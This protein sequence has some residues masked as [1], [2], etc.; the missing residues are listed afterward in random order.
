MEMK[1]CSRK[2]CSFGDQLQSLD[3]FVK[4]KESKDGLSFLCKSCIQKYRIQNKE[5]IS[6]KGR[7]YY[8][9]NKDRI[10]ERGRQRYTQNKDR[11]LEKNKQ[12]NLDHRKETNEY[13]RKKRHEDLYFKIKDK[14]RTRMYCAIKGNY[15]SGSAVADLMMSISDF[16]IYL[17]E[18][19]YRNPDTG[20]MMT[21]DNYGRYPG[22]HIDHIIPL[23][24]FDL[25][26]RE[27]LLKAVRYSNLQPMWAKENLSKG[28]RYE[29]QAQ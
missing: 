13:M 2:D 23:A 21:W 14:L 26:N 12:Y 20:E 24:A 8:I 3:N 4:R 10:I 18:R 22:W 25:T 7:Q 17:E 28:A 11:I 9:Q 27:E 29:N 19:F 6:E 1:V 15:K 16:K 5:K